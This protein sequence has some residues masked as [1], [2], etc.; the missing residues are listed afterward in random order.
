[1][2][3][4]L[5]NKVIVIHKNYTIKWNLLMRILDMRVPAYNIIHMTHMFSSGMYQG[6]I[7]VE[8]LASQIFGDSL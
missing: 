5:H 6:T 2:S 1:M 4:T 7:Y 3:T 8:L